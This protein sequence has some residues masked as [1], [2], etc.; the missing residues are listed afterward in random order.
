[1]CI[2]VKSVKNRASVAVLIE[3]G[4]RISLTSAISHQQHLPFS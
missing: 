4:Q 3:N 1:M 2:A